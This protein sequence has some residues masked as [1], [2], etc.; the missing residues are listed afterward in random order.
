[1]IFKVLYL[2]KVFP[3]FASS[4][5]ILLHMKKKYFS[6]IAQPGIQILNGL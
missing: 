5:N 2:S 6:L 3:T 1:M 4:V